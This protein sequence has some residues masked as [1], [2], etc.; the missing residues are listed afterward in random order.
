MD[1]HNN[2]AIEA[3]KAVPPTAWGAAHYFGMALPDLLNWLTFAYLVCLLVQMAYRM[4]RFGREWL[5]KRAVARADLQ[6]VYRFRE[7]GAA[8]PRALT[9][10][11]A[12]AIAIVA[13]S[14][15]G[16]E[17]QRFTAYADTGGTWTICEG[18]TR[19]VKPGDHATP[20]QCA[21]YKAA[22]LTEASQGVDSCTH[23]TLTAYE[24]AAYVDFV[25]NVGKTAYCNSTMLQK[26]NAGYH[27]EACNQLL[28]WTYA[29]GKQ[30]PGLINRRRAER[31][32]CLRGLQK[33][34]T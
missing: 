23:A 21:G 10:L 18:H 6:R 26:L 15:S 29:G 31:D 20:E 2:F 25:Y 28:R 32:L 14:L 8:N 24:R 19:D 13:A 7:R 16:F 22:D 11:A 5:R 34:Q 3:G 17:G 1:E 27:V 33:G 12:A 9:A 30:L 4:Q